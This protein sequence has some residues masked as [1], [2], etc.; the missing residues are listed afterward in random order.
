MRVIQVLDALDFG[1]GV[2]NDVIHLHEMHILI[3]CICGSFIPNGVM[4]RCSTI[5][6]TLKSATLKRMIWYYTTFLEK[7]LFVIL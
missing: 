1:D 4:K 6:M 5:P 3:N 2:S 7:V